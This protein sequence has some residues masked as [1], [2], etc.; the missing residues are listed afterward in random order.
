M[1]KIMETHNQFKYSHKV[2]CNTLLRNL[3]TPIMACEPTT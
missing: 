1:Y 2:F 3:E